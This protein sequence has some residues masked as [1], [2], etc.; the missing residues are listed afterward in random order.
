MPWHV[1]D[2]VKWNGSGTGLRVYHG[3]IAALNEVTAVVVDDEWGARSEVR[4]DRLAPEEVCGACGLL[5]K[6]RGERCQC[7]NP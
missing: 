3:V 1:G 5:R 6:P 4:Y 7:P 2:F